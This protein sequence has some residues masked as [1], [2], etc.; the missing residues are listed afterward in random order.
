V[1]A[2]RLEQYFGGPAWRRVRPS[3]DW[4]QV[5]MLELVA[6]CLLLDR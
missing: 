2:Q 5:W 6:C 3:T 4:P 1:A